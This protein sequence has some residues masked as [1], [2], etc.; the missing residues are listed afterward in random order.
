MGVETTI[1]NQ[2]FIELLEQNNQKM[3]PVCKELV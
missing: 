2:Q 3:N 1:L